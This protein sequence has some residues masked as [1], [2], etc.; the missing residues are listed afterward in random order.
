MV[1]RAAHRARSDAASSTQLLRQPPASATGG[2]KPLSRTDGG[3]PLGQRQ[4]R[5]ALRRRR[6]CDAP[7]GGRLHLGHLAREHPLR[8]SK[9]KHLRETPA[10]RRV[11]VII[12]YKE[13]R[14]CQVSAC[15]SPFCG[16]KTPAAASNPSSSSLYLNWRVAVTS[17]L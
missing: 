8:R 9:M 3:F 1:Y 14:P 17:S 11:Q 2:D 16:G 13:P 6:P 4:L 10:F 5:G 7:P 15:P 12:S